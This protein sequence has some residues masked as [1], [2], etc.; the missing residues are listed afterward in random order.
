MGGVMGERPYFGREDAPPHA[1]DPYTV[2]SVHTILLELL[3]QL[4]AV[5]K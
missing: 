4:T 1:N 2:E 3:K 5:G